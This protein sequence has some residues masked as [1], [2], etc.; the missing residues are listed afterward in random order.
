MSDFKELVLMED[1]DFEEQAP[2]KSAYLFDDRATD[3][4][5]VIKSAEAGLEVDYRCVKCRSCCDCKKSDKLEVNIL[6]ATL[7]WN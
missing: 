4:K 2:T 7:L 6:A 5:A 1:K 3:L